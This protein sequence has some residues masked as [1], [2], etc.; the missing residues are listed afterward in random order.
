[1]T[2]QKWINEEMA[3]RPNVK[4]ATALHSAMV[5]KGFIVSQNSLYVWITGRRNPGARSLQD[6]EKFFGSKYPG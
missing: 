5:K 4:N 2:A 3:K 1:M 6:M